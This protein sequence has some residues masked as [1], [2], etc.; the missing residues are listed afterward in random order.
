ML[1]TSTERKPIKQKKPKA[2]AKPRFKPPPRTYEKVSPRGLVDSGILANHRESSR[3]ADWE[4]GANF[5]HDTL[6][7]EAS[8]SFLHN[9]L[10]CW[11]TD[12]CKVWTIILL[13]SQT[14]AMMH[15]HNEYP[16]YCGVIEV[17]ENSF[18][19]PDGLKLV[20]TY[21]MTKPHCTIIASFPCPEGGMLN[22]SLCTTVRGR[23]E[24]EC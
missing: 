21:L 7:H 6:G 10:S 11:G 19:T 20:S 24:R 18:A 17:E 1:K 12:E 8:A 14:D 23:V 4:D 5:S 3:Q 9:Q 15:R 16:A 22:F 13:S 2:K